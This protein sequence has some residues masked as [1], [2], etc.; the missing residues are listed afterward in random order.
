VEHLKS[1][2]IEEYRVVGERLE[3]VGVKARACF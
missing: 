1:M 2:S 3:T